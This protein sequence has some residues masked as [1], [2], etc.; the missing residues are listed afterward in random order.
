MKVFIYVLFIVIGN[1]YCKAQSL[2]VPFQL[3]AD[4]IVAT[5]EYEHESCNFIIDTGSSL[6]IVDSIFASNLSLKFG[7]K[8]KLQTI[9]GEVPCYTT[10]FQLWENFLQ[11]NWKILSFYQESQRLGIQIDGLIGALSIAQHYNMLFDF[12]N[13]MITIDHN[14]E[15]SSNNAIR[16]KLISFSNSSSILSK[17]FTPLLVINEKVLINNKYNHFMNLVIDTGCRYGL[18]L[19]VDDSTTIRNNSVLSTEMEL[20]GW[21]K[22]YNFCKTKINGKYDSDIHMSPFLYSPKHTQLM[23]NKQFGLLGPPALKKFKKILIDTKDN[24][25]IMV[26]YQ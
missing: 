22:R 9:I 14:I 16:Y 12:E 15:V 10:D 23:N 3:V 2:T 1:G 17:Y 21:T 13:Q 20:H 19:V 8:T 4:R 11:K 25:L 5:I 18:A 7:E 24:E 6:S 26:P